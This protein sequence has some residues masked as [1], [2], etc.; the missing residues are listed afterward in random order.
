MAEVATEKGAIVWTV[1]NGEPEHV[2]KR[3]RSFEGVERHRTKLNTEWPMS[4]DTTQVVQT[5]GVTSRD[6]TEALSNCWASETS[7]DITRA[8]DSQKIRDTCRNGEVETN[9]SQGCDTH[10]VKEHS[11]E[12]NGFPSKT[13]ALIRSMLS[14]TRTEEL[15]VLRHRSKISQHEESKSSRVGSK[16]LRNE[17]SD[18]SQC[19]D[20]D[21]VA[22]LA[23]RERHPRQ[24][25]NLDLALGVVR[26]GGPKSMA[27]ELEKDDFPSGKKSKKSKHVTAKES[28]LLRLFESK[29]FDMSIA[30]QYLFNSKEPGV[31]SYIGRITITIR[32]IIVILII[33]IIV[34]IVTITMITLKMMTMTMIVTCRF[35]VCCTTHL[36]A[37]TC[38]SVPAGL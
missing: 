25:T 19:D 29:L 14:R 21:N 36:G 5:S 4:I 22:T 12:K 8:T 9:N 20:A 28:W 26:N 3:S 31:Q 10:L 11:S 7:L 30:I 24:R 13:G 34:I 18:M 38:Y 23:S 2:Y 32:V 16:T 15:K 33:I 1:M 35:T 27:E 17:E 6:L 37:A